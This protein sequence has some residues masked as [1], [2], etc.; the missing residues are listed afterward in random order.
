M[1]KELVIF[2]LRGK[3]ITTPERKDGGEVNLRIIVNEALSVG[4][5][6]ATKW[7]LRAW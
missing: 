7:Q 6:K 1:E 3:E 5:S 2:T 4:A